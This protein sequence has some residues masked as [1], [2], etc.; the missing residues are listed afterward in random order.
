MSIAQK[1][2]TVATNQQKVY[3]AGKN[4]EYDRFWDEFQN[5]GDRTNYTYAFAYGGW[6]D[7][8]Y[9]PKYTIRP[10][11]CNNMFMNASSI[12]DTKV[13]IDLTNPDGNQKYGLFASATKLM[14]IQ[15][16]I[17]DKTITFQSS[18]PMFN[19]CNSLK[20]ITFEGAIGK[21]ISFKDCPLLSKESIENIV[22]CLSSDSADTTLTLSQ[23][24]VDNAFAEGEWDT[25]IADKTNWNFSLV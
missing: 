12:T 22:S 25:L 7:D 2:T 14:T 15:K 24:A 23:T 6:N 9:N 20:N 11:S 10:V 18:S 19:K 17:V 13:T 4:A 5:Y 8:T 21:D 1:L 16:L 3:D